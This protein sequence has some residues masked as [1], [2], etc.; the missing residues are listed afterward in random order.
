[1]QIKGEVKIRLVNRDGSVRDAWQQENL[2]VNAG[3]ATIMHR[4]GGDAAYSTD[5]FS[6][7]AFGVTATAPTLG[8]TRHLTGDYNYIRPVTI[9]YPYAGQLILSSTLSFEQGVGV[10][11]RELAAL[12][13]N[14]LFSRITLGTP[15]IKTADFAAYIDW[16]FSIQ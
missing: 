13:T 15:I 11:F 3:K 4:L 14:H 10:S 9:T 7:I 16:F 5:V 6:G 1:M 12:T 8:D 2:I